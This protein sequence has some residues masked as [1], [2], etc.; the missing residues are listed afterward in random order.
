MP[1]ARPPPSVGVPRGRGQPARDSW[2]STLL[3]G[4]IKFVVAMGSQANSPRQ[5]GYAVA[6]GHVFASQWSRGWTARDR[7]GPQPVEPPAEVAMGSQARV[8][9]QS[10]SRRRHRAARSSQWSRGPASRDTR[11]STRTSRGCTCRNGVA[12]VHPA[13]VRAA[14]HSARRGL[15]TMGS[16][17]DS[18]RQRAG[19]C[20]DTRGCVVAMESQ[21][22]NPRQL[23]RSASRAAPSRRNG[24][25]G[26]QP[27]TVG[28]YGAYY[29]GG[30]VVGNQPATGRGGLHGHRRRNGV[31]G[32]QPATV[33]GAIGFPREDGRNGVAGTQPATAEARDMERSGEFVAM[34]SQAR[35]P[36]QMDDG[37]VLIPVLTSQWSRR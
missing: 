30:G 12:G 27:A 14:W 3:L 16:R 13:T 32:T 18:P 34:E 11:R 31:A 35:I 20:R 8:A 29:F 36:R 15:L 9:R 4:Q 33:V 5:L 19:T 21:A 28:A 6:P 1:G 2:G 10:P 22:D 17:A 37:G 26:G 23:S 7:Q 25:A 24:V